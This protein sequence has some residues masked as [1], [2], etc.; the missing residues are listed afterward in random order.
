MGKAC[1]ARGKTSADR[2]DYR[3][4]CR[5]WKLG[6]TFTR[7]NNDLVKA[8]SNVCTRRAGETLEKAS[9][10]DQLKAVLD[11]AVDGDGFKE[12]VQQRLADEGC[13]VD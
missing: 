1:Y 2:N 11:F 6:S 10:C 8:L 13:R 5:V 7:G 9:G 4:A 3:Q 12:K